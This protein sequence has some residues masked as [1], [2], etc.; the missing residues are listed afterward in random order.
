[1]KQKGMLDR[2]VQAQIGRLLRDIFADVAEEPVPKRFVELLEA[3]ETKEK[4]P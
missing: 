2:S 4:Q 3:L 1:M